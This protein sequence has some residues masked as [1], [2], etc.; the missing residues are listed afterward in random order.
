MKTQQNASVQENE[1]RENGEKGH[2]WLKIPVEQELYQPPRAGVIL[3]QVLIGIFFFLLVIRFWYLQMHKGE[4]FAR[5]AIEN[6]MRQEYVLAPRGRILD[7]HD[8]IL[9]DNRTTYG[10]FLIRED[11]LDLPATLA[12]ISAC[13]YI[14]PGKKGEI[15]LNGAAARMAQVGDKII[16]VTFTWIDEEKAGDWL[17]NV[18]LLDEGNKIKEAGKHAMV[19][20][21]VVV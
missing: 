14:I 5:Q 18:V 8:R 20:G 15:C 7:L 16:I 10:L 11:C 17:P 6:R 21:T 3:L 19:S 12:Q 4:F 13:T 9:T 1:E 2:S